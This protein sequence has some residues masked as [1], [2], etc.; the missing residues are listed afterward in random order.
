MENAYA[1][2][3]MH[4]ANLQVTTN[5]GKITNKIRKK[6]KLDQTMPMYK[7]KTEKKISEYELTA[8][9]D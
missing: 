5:Q 4:R 7:E 9:R 1:F 3:A 8:L 6:D 2:R